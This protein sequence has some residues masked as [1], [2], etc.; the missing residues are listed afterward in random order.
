MDKPVVEPPVTEVNNEAV[1]DN[2]LGEGEAKVGGKVSIPAIT[3]YPKKLITENQ[4]LTTTKDIIETL[5]TNNAETLVANR[6]PTQT[7]AEITSSILNVLLHTTLF[8]SV[9]NN[10]CQQSLN[11]ML[12]K[13]A[14]DYVHV[15]E[16]HMDGDLTMQQAPPLPVHNPQAFSTSI[17]SWV[18]NPI[19]HEGKQW[20]QGHRKCKNYTDGDFNVIAKPDEYIG[21]ARPDV[22][23]IRDSTSC[24]NDCHM[25]ELPFS[26]GGFKWS[27]PQS[28]EHVSKH[29]D[30]VLVNQYWVSIFP[31]AVVQHLCRSP[32]DHSPLLLSWMSCSDRVS[33]QFRFQ[34]MWTQHHAFRNMVQQSWV[35]PMQCSGMR[36]LAE[37]LKRLKKTLQHKNKNTFGDVYGNI[38]VVEPIMEIKEQAF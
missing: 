12:L 18:G 5:A 34:Q 13:Q 21:R 16:S 19:A 6:T 23:A 7:L 29:L 8:T 17:S 1:K 15:H 37:K 9:P 31:M 10:I 22:G 2:R 38:K 4:T 36:G 25:L 14:R 3:C 26:G 11:P 24:I 32:S 20:E 28:G 30:C 27:G 33:L 35:A